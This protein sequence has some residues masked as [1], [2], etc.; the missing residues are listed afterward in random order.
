MAFCHALILAA[1]SQ[2]FPQ[3]TA[4]ASASRSALECLARAN[5]KQLSYEVH[6]APNPVSQEHE[7]DTM[8]SIEISSAQLCL[9]CVGAFGTAAFGCLRTKGD[10]CVLTSRK[11][12][13]LFHVLDVEKLGH[14][15]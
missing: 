7:K 9:L 5:A 11:V 13:L 6:R 4:D 8:L 15:F 2:H 14:V 12:F 10:F 1:D 3:R